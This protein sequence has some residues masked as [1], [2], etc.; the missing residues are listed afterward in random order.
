[1]KRTNNFKKSCRTMK[2]TIYAEENVGITKND[3]LVRSIAII[4]LQKD[5]P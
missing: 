5:K 2:T 1:M 4:T 3:L